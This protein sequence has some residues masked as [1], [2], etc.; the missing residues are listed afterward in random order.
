MS[1]GSE[2]PGDDPLRT[3]LLPGL[4]RGLLEPESTAGAVHLP[5]VQTGVQPQTPAEQKHGPR[6]GG[7]EV[8]AVRLSEPSSGQ[9]GE[10][11][12]VSDSRRRQ[13]LRGVRPVVLPGSPESPRRQLSREEGPQV[14]SGHGGSERSPVPPSPQVTDVVLS[15]RPELRVFPLCEGETQEPRRR[16]GGGA[17]GSTA[18]ALNVLTFTSHLKKL[19]K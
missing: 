18:G 9:G 6:R 19:F 1:G 13:V 16:V 17:E 7:R 8:P 14:D 2:G 3:Q 12:R 4:H 5:P 11:Q 10:M 15:H